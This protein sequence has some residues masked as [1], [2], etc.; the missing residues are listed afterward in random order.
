V[1]LHLRALEIGDPPEAWAALGVAVDGSGTA[2][3]GEVALHLRTGEPRGV[4]AWTLQGLPAGW[5]GSLDGLPTVAS[6]DPT[7][8]TAGAGA[9]AGAGGSAEAGAQAGAGTRDRVSP[10]PGNVAADRR[11]PRSIDHV[12]VATPDVDRTVAAFSAAGSEPRRERRAG[13]ADVPMRQVFFRLGGTIAEVVG[14]L[15]A[16]GEGPATFWGLV[17]VVDDLDGAARALGDAVGPVRD[18]VQPGRR[19]ATVRHRVL[20]LS[21]ATALMSP[22]AR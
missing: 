20:G 19:I 10:D 16:A 3:V 17:L 1:T 18:A 11:A 2:Q 6:T 4:R 21:V 12:V 13:T 22:H 14:P 9:A 7:P 15:T 8:A 5:A